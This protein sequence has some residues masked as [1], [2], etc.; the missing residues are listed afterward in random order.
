MRLH[1]THAEFNVRTLIEWLLLSMQRTQISDGVYE[2]SANEYLDLCI[3][4]NALLDTAGSSGV[5]DIQGGA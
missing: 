2:L 3:K 5:K 4:F 1:I